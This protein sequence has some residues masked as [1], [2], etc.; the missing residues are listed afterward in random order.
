MDIPV[1]QLHGTCE[2]L[3]GKNTLASNHYPMT[4]EVNLVQSNHD[5]V[6]LFFK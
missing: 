6:S 2:V 4:H 1:S 3:Q 5:P